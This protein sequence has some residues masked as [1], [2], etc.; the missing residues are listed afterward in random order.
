[1]GVVQKYVKCIGPKAFICRSVWR[2][3]KNHCSWVITNKNGFFEKDNLTEYRKY[4]TN[5]KIPFSSTIVFTNRGR[6]VENT[7]PYL[8]NI[9]K[10]LKDYAYVSLTELVGDFIEDESGIWWL[11]N[12]RAYLLEPS[13]SMNLRYITNFGEEEHC[14]NAGWTPQQKQV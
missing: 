12:V 14:A 13:P 3:D 2:K 1:M 8:A 9:V 11:I 7:I 6:F 4:C 5:P 10:F